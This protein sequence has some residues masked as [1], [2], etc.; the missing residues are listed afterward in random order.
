MSHDTSLLLFAFVAIVFLIFL[1]AKW[2]LNAFVALVLASLFVG[3]CSGMNLADI[4]KSFGEGVGAVLSSVAIVVGLGTIL[5]KLL[6]ESGGAEVVARTL[7]KT[8]GPKRLPWTMMVV[9]F[10]VGMPVWFTVGLVLLIPIVFTVAR[11]TNTPLL[12]LGIPLVAGLSVAHGLVPPHPGPMVAIELLKADP[13]KTILYSLIVGLPTAVIAGPIF[14]RYIAKKVQVE[15]GG[16]G[17]QLAKK[18]A[19]GT[20]PGFALTLLTILAPILLMM[21]A[22]VVD[23]V[24]P[25]HKENFAVLIVSVPIQKSTN[26]VRVIREINP[27]LSLPEAQRFLEASAPP[28]LGNLSRSDAE[29]ARKRLQEAGAAV[30]LQGNRLREWSSFL[31]HPTV[32]MLLGVLFAFYSFGLARGFDKQQ[33]SKFSEECLAPVALVLLVVGAGGGFSRVLMHSGVSQAMAELVK[34][35]DISLLCFGWLVAALIRIATGSAT[36]AISTAAGIVAPMA[37][38]APAT[39]TE[40]L[41]IAMGAGSAIL[42]HLNDGGFW[43]VKEYLNMSVPQTLKTW[44]VMETI[45]SLVGLAFVLLLDALL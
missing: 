35:A 42:S 31:G 6:A 5:G 37:A 45:V 16:I 15:L 9:A 41:I 12:T 1:I 14:G 32:A 40:L 21:L 8:L 26:V 25:A 11:E 19:T 3:F 24:S 23:V 4:A 13:G 2:K 29:S 43:F 22:T 28:L 38:G 30:R 27:T 39:N 18:S 10:V 34:G 20:L 44:T 17:A 36:V 33:L 7:I